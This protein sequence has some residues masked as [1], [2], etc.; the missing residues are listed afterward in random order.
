MKFVA[1]ES[2]GGNYMVVAQNVAWLRA[3]ENGQTNVGIV[4]GDQLLVV[5]SPEQVAA[6]ILA[7]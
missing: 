6:I 5:G 2:R 3:A 4:G 1:L 7:G